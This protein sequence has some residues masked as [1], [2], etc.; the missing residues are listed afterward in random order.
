LRICAGATK[1]RHWQVLHRLLL[2]EWHRLK[3]EQAAILGQDRLPVAPLKSWYKSL[4]IPEEIIP[5]PGHNGRDARKRRWQG[6]DGVPDPASVL[7]RQQRKASIGKKTGKPAVDEV[8]RILDDGGEW[9]E[10]T[11]PEKQKYGRL[12]SYRERRAK[13][14]AELEE[15]QRQEKQG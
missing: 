13:R 9:R 2:D 14:R 12:P 8:G 15:A 10:M 5:E 6:A 4:E 1:E 11:G 3:T 7:E